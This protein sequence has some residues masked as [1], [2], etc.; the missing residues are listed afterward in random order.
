MGNQI[1]ITFS[2]EDAAAFKAWQRQQQAAAKMK[3]EL[4][5][6]KNSGNMAGQQ[7]LGAARFAGREVLAGMA[8]LTGIGGAVTALT[9]IASQL[10]VE[11][12]NIRSRQTEAGGTQVDFGKAI[13]Q[14]LK[15]LGGLLDPTEFRQAI[16]DAAERAGQ[17]QTTMA[18]VVGSALA[19]VGAGTP[20][21]ARQVI[22]SGEKAAQVYAELETPE[23]GIAAGGMAAIKRSAKLDD[24]EAAGLMLATGQQHRSE[25]TQALITNVIPDIP[26][27]MK[28][29]F[30]AQEAA[31]FL[32]SFSQMMGDKEGSTSGTA[33]I[34]TAK[35]L[36]ERFPEIPTAMGRIE[37]V[38]SSP[39][40]FK[41]YMQ[42]GTYNGRNFGEASMGRGEAYTT[43]RGL[44]RGDAS[45]VGDLKS[46]TDSIG[47]SN[48]WRSLTR[49]AIQ[50]ANKIP[51]VVQMRVQQ[52]L[53]A[54]TSGLQLADMSGGTAGIARDNL[55]EIL[56]A[57]GLSEVETK[58]SIANF[59]WKTGLG[60]KL[61]NS[62][63]ARQLEAQA[64]NTDQPMTTR[65]GRAAGPGGPAIEFH[66]RDPSKA[67]DEDRL[68][69]IRL[70][71][72][73]NALRQ[74]DVQ[75]QAAQGGAKR[76]GLMTPE[77]IRAA[78]DGARQAAEEIERDKNITA[79]EAASARGKV[80]SAR[81]TVRGM[82]HGLTKADFRELMGALF[83]DS[84]VIE[85]K[86]QS[87]SP[88]AQAVAPRT[89]IPSSNKIKAA[90]DSAPIATEDRPSKPVTL[91]AAQASATG[92][93][94][95]NQLGSIVQGLIVS[96]QKL[97]ESNKVLGSKLDTNSQITAQANGGGASGNQVVSSPPRGPVRNGQASRSLDRRNQSSSQKT[98]T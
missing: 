38:Q 49:Q 27:L 15:N 66:G 2:V 32:S 23:K 26:K 11:V 43:V 57:S 85:S 1:E 88:S 31:G 52:M 97:E 22:A 56:K 83:T 44:M 51:E 19:G 3:K 36:A 77:K 50:D 78:L 94:G 73:A 48:K 63:V 72:S 35:E 37:K 28:L 89:G 76:T 53:K 80:R 24:D 69:A 34:I 84:N 70:R 12:A 45:E 61:A 67:T 4:D 93:P 39:A 21:E 40:E 86:I 16:L 47:D 95:L 41:K 46:R 58:A 9:A 14:S 20:E 64:L 55:Q 92:M 33:A 10:R 81:D 60:G 8:A 17:D 5:A 59:E 79:E 71:A 25:T 91:P 62:E 6:L 13:S 75:S 54:T 87:Q 68:K 18:V 90:L 82:E 74:L 7:M 96:N 98:F 29:D 42:G 30:S 65:Y